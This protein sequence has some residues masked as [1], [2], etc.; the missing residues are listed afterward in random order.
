MGHIRCI[1]HDL[2]EPYAFAR[3]YDLIVVLWYVNLPLIEQLCDCLAAGG[4]LLCEEHLRS[5]QA[6]IGPGNP[7]FRVAPDALR[8]AVSSLELRSTGCFVIRD[9]SSQVR[10]PATTADASS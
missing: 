10:S 6:V 7:D 4:Y 9:T 1:E 2:D 5:D 8:N 3:D